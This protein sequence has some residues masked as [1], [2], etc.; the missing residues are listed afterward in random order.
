MA[1]LNYKWIGQMFAALGVII[2]LCLVAYE[3]KL[4]RDIALAELSISLHER[5]GDRELAF[6]ETSELVSA[7]IKF[8]SGLEDELT[9]RERVA[10]NAALSHGLYNLESAFLL[11]QMGLLPRAEWQAKREF[12]KLMMIRSPLIRESFGP[13]AM[14]Q[15]PDME[16]EFDEIRAEVDAYLAEGNP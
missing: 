16:R 7:R 9:P 5:S 13:Q 12:T 4:A 11:D 6:I 14:I 15:R 3:M 10:F 8:F 2:S 1:E